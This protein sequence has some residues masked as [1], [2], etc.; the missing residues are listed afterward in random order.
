M[1]K[2]LIRNLRKKPKTTRDSIA[3]GVAGVFTFMVFSV[4][5]YN[6][7]DRF[8]TLSAFGELES[9]DT[10][11]EAGFSSFFTNLRDQL[12]GVAQSVEE[13]VETEESGTDAMDTS[14]SENNSGNT[15]DIQEMINTIA[16]PTT[17]TSTSSK[18]RNPEASLREVRIITTTQSTSSA[19]SPAP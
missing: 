6:T 8:S 16:R 11:E 2:S 1:V 9:G 14:S 15:M 4:W 10:I 3:F 19:T 13:V 17:T 12:A 7:P 5:A 18:P